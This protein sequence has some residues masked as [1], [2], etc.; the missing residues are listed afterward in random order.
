MNAVLEKRR[1]DAGA[2]FR[3]AGIPHRRIEDWKYSDLRARIDDAQAT[4]MRSAP[5][6]LGA[7][8]AGVEVVDLAKADLPEWVTRSL[9]TVSTHGAMDSAALAFGSGGLA[10]RVS[11]NVPE[12]VRLEFVGTGHARLLVV[13]EAGAA[14]TLV[15]THAPDTGLRNIASELVLGEGARLAHI[16]LAAEAPSG[17][18]VG[19]IAAAL[20]ERADYCGHYTNF[21]AELSRVDTNIMLKG[22]GA[23]A[24]LSG[25]DVLSGS[26]HSDVTT[27]VDHAVG[28]TT[29]TQLF[30]KVAGGKAR[31]VY[32]GKV[33]VRQGADGSDSRQTAKG[34]L[35]SERAEIDLKP[36]LEIFADDVKCAHGAAV[37]DLDPDSLFYLRARGVPEAEARNL[38]VHAFVADA[39][40]AIENDDLRSDVLARIEAALV[41]AGAA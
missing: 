30:K 13:L 1:A 3:A 41:R 19:S 11:R 36:E 9:G 12:P 40:E 17:V 37:G 26:T 38:L 2:A 14:V 10:M 31:S 22:K 15:E 6:V 20:D 18:T 39:V 25:V 28:H 23:S 27:H 24:R 7:V 16:R 34:L 32:Q 8:P 5:W 29:S 33:T 21:G 4:E 35:L